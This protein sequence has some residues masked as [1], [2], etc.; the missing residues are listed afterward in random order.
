VL[1][2]RCLDSSDLVW[3]DYGNRLAFQCPLHED[4]QPSGYMF[5]SELRVRCSAKDICRAGEGIALREVGAIEGWEDLV[6]LIDE[7]D[8]IREDKYSCITLDTMQ[9][10]THYATVT[11]FAPYTGAI[12]GIT[13]FIIK[14][15]GER[16]QLLD[17]TSASIM[18]QLSYHALYTKPKTVY[19]PLPPG[20][21]KSTWM[22]Q[23]IRWMLQNDLPAAGVVIAVERIEDAKAL[24][25]A[26]GTY[27]VSRQGLGI[28]APYWEPRDATYVMETAFTSNYCVKRPEKFSYGYCRGCEE[29]STC[30]TFNK[31]RE[32]ERHPVVIISHARLGMEGE[33][34]NKYTNWVDANGQ[35]HR[36]RLLIIDEK[37]PIVQTYPLSLTLVLETEGKL[38][39]IAGEAG[40]SVD[41]TLELLNKVKDLYTSAPTGFVEPVDPNFK[42]D[43]YSAWYKYYHGDK[44]E[45]LEW[46]EQLIQEGG[47]LS[48][49]QDEKS[50]ITVSRVNPFDFSEYT[51]LI[52]DGTSYAD[53]EYRSLHAGSFLEV[54]P[55]IRDYENLEV[56]VLNQSF[57]KESQRRKPEIL[58]KI[59]EQ[60][61]GCAAAEKTLVL[62]YKD[63]RKKLE[64]ELE[65]EVKSGQVMVNHFGNVKGSNS[66]NDCTAL[67]VLG[68]Y[69]KGDSYYLA[70]GKVL[71]D[72]KPKTKTNTIKSV[73]RFSDIQVERLKLND[74]L[75]A[76]IQDI[77][78]TAIRN[79][80]FA[81]TVKIYI[82]TRDKFFIEALAQYF[83]GCSVKDWEVGRV[84]ESKPKWYSPLESL[85]TT[86]K[87]GEIIAKKTLKEAAGLSDRNFRNVVS[88][89]HFQ[90]LLQQHGVKSYNSQKYK[91]IA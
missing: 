69:H 90:H 15:F 89:Q 87:P 71:S 58:D 39:Q 22:H 84:H 51:T 48:Q 17:E 21:G 81:D 2:H 66:Y 6:P 34:L 77:C 1:I 65:A 37:P 4:T 62:C 18:R 40:I 33:R 31:Y 26:L 73:R 49:G 35:Q 30:P 9:A 38:R 91:R 75:V 43:V 41:G 86:L 10:G 25:S 20:G 68:S 72:E 27:E 55:S 14:T 19:A 63:S 24:A 45:S 7:L 13:G 50:T 16:G 44:A 61:K 82:P 12:N 79:K 23:Y 64:A 57:G 80:G 74:Q 5:K 46:I 8:K 83:I 29:R 28:D 53:M 67:F 76:V 47:Y 85:I 78:R 70:R 52:L 36:R 88:T 56:H 32:Q 60:I 3:H 54:P 59:V 42:S 11:D